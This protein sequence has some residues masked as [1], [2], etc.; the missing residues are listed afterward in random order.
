[1]FISLIESQEGH[2]WQCYRS[3][4]V[5]LTRGGVGKF[6]C[7]FSTHISGIKFRILLTR[8]LKKKY[9]YIDRRSLFIYLFKCNVQVNAVCFH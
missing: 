6:R 3:Q 4:R 5:A 1:M 9:I 2:V 8:V 7:F